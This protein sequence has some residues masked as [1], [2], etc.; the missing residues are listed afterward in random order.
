LSASACIA[1]ADGT[2][3]IPALPEELNFI[4]VASDDPDP[5]R[6]L[7]GGA[8]LGAR[9]RDRPAGRRPLTTPARGVTV[10][11]LSFNAEVRD[12]ARHVQGPRQRHPHHRAAR[13]VAAVHRPS[14]P[15]ASATRAHGG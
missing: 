5:V 15:G 13:S 2:P 7:L 9:S 12:G 6:A 1:Q 4:S 11:T 3:I 14:L 10:P 8:A